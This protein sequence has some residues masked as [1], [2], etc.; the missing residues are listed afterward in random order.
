MDRLRRVIADV[1]SIAV[2]A[3]GEDIASAAR[4]LA[5]ER[6]LL[7]AASRPRTAAA[8]PL[9]TVFGQAPQWV[10]SERATSPIPPASSASMKIVL[11]RLVG[12]K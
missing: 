8:R 6:K 2:N 11:K 4:D 9:A 1:E 12:R 5:L 7:R 3:L 10:R